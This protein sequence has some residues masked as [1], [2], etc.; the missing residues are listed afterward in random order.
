MGTK[1][2]RPLGALF[3]AA[4]N[5]L[6]L[7]QET[8]GKRF[9]ASRKTVGRWEAGVATPTEATTSEVIR[10]V[11]PADPQLAAEMATHVHETLDSLGLVAPPAPPGPAP[12]VR[13][14]E[15]AVS[16]RH[17]VDSIVCVAADAM[18]LLPRA[19]RPAVLAAFTRAREL[20]LDVK[21]VEAALLPEGKKR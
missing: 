9:G 18:E 11:F 8:M 10:S 21:T 19:V 2:A 20:G 6:S 3:S 15:P 5:Q 1:N 16:P 4:R 17:M 14:P 13:D 7:T 12:V